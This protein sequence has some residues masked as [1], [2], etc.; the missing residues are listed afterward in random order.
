MLT[1]LRI[2]KSVMISGNTN[3]IGTPPI[4]IKDNNNR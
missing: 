4:T 2:P 1:L 3:N